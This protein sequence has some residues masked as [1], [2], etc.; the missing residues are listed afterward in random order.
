MYNVKISEN[1]T[2]KMHQTWTN[3]RITEWESEASK[4]NENISN[5]WNEIMS[6]AL[7][8]KTQDLFW[9]EPCSGSSQVALFGSSVDIRTVFSAFDSSSYAWL[10]FWYH[11]DV[12]FKMF[13]FLFMCFALEMSEAA[14]NFWLIF[15]TKSCTQTT[16]DCTS[17]YET[18]TNG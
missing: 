18:A 2:F 1:I 7:R 13:C 17:G 4:T 9:P 5:D 12:N 14:W 16:W 10:L 3:R 8:R 15:A 11:R 6:L